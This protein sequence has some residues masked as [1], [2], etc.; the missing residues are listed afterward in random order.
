MPLEKVEAAVDA[1]FADVAKNGVT[2]AELQRAKSGYISDYIYESDNQ[3]TLARRYGWNLTVGRT[4]AD[5]EAWPAAI[6]KV[7]LDNVKKAAADY[8]DVRRS[9]TG[10]LV[11]DK[12]GVAQSGAPEAAPVPASVVR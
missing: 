12:S 2:E 3:A 9:V 1:V 6:A 10:Y 11:P 5:I 4:V 7:S 8:L